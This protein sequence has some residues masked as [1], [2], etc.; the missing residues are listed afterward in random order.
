LTKSGT[1]ARLSL[2][3]TAPREI[4]E[5]VQAADWSPDGSELAII[6]QA[7]GKC[8]LEF[9]IGKVLYETGGYLSDLRVSPRGDVIALFEHPRLFDDRG[10]VI[11]VDRAGKRTLLSGDY[12]SEG[13][14]S[15]SQT[16][17]E[18]LFTANTSG[19]LYVYTLYGVNLSG[20]RRVALS[21]PGGLKMQDVSRTGRWL[22]TRDDSRFEIFGMAPG[23]TAERNLSWTGSSV[24]PSLSRDGRM[25]LF[26]D[27]SVVSG[28]NYKV[29]LRKTDGGPVVVLGEGRPWGFRWEVGTRHHRHAAAGRDLPDRPWRSEAPSQRAARGLPRSQLVP[30]RKRNPGGCQRSGQAFAMLC[31]GHL[32][33]LATAGHIRRNPGLHFS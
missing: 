8:R 24:E 23:E 14:L 2:G 29:C 27:M 4:L 15:W 11:L 30:G 10:S 9:P 31:A 22:V 16:G 33:R 26:T 12:E 25:L 1:L 7:N 5:D 17:D 13:G 20:R 6:R 21:A 18:V 3:G 32:G 19:G 28:P